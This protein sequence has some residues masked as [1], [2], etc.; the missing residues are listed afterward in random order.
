[1][2]LIIQQAQYSS[3]MYEGRDRDDRDPR[4]SP[5]HDVDLPRGEERAGHRS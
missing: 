5:M 1:V 2:V 3:S 4:D